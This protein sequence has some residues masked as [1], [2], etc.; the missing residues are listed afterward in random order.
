VVKVLLGWPKSWSETGA[1]VLVAYVVVQIACILLG[2]VLPARFMRK[3]V[4][5]STLRKH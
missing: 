4:Q 3:F 1:N 2:T 5:V